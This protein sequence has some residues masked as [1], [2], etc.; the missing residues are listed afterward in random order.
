MTVNASGTYTA[1]ASINGCSSTSANTTVIVNPLPTGSISAGGSTSFCEGDSVQ[2]TVSTAPGNSI[3]WSNGATTQNIWVKTGGSYSVQLTSAQGCTATT[4]SISTTVLQK[5]SPV[6]GQ[7][8][9]ELS[10]S[11]AASAYQWY[12]NGSAISGATGQTITISQGGDYSVVVTGSNGCKATAYHSAV[13]RVNTS[14]IAYQAYPNPVTAD[15]RL[16]YT[17][18]E[19]G[20]VTFTILDDQGRQKLVIPVGHQ[21]PGDHQ[22]TIRNAAMRLGTGFYLL[23][24]TVGDKQVVH[25]ILVL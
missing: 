12:L 13:F 14:F 16:A 15:L 18:K 10:V 1:T 2:L 22:Y 11:P 8:G 3:L 7:S 23:K 17:L 6:I 20:H 9:N 5:P 4:N 25:R 21:A 19:G 24:I